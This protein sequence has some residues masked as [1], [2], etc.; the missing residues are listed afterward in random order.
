[1][2]RTIAI[3]ITLV[4]AALAL[5]ASAD[6][7][8][9]CPLHAQHMAAA[10]KTNADGSTT[11][12]TDVD[13][14]HD[15][16]VMSHETTHHSF[17]LF[18]DGGAIELVATSADDAATID[19]VRTHVRMIADQFAANDFST[20]MFVHG[21]TPDG[22]ADMKRLHDDIKFQF[23]TLPA[24][25]RIHMTTSNSEAL[26]ALHAFLRFQVVEHRT[27]DTGVVESDEAQHQ[28]QHQH[29]SAA[30][31]SPYTDRTT[32]TIKALDQETIDAYR[33]GTGHGMAIATELNGYPGPRHVLDLAEKLQLSDV[34]KTAVKKAFDAMHEAAVPLGL[35]IIDREKAL[36]DLF[37]RGTPSD[38]QVAKLTAEIADL[39]GRLRSTHLTAHLTTKTLL[40][41]EQVRTY[42]AERGYEK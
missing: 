1:M 34:Q 39:Q 25:A 19:A 6:D 33:Q 37:A 31:H 9:S 14:R 26:A 22:I 17:R 20:P 24:G 21:K 5:P 12:G 18:K 30:T 42:E 36:D 35:Q 16:L 29:A 27:G 8:S 10:A 23:E 7:M 4:I 38:R 28:H 32:L 13:H 41:P 11:H 40:T 2:S 3:S 15:T